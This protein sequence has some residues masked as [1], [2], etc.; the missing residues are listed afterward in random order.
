MFCYATFV[1]KFLENCLS[2]LV[3]HST[4]NHTEVV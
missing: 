1:D 4:C 2:V 3:A